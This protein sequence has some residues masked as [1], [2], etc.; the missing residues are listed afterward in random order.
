MAVFKEKTPCMA[1][2]H[3]IMDLILYEMKADIWLL[4]SS[5]TARF[6]FAPL[7]GPADHS[8]LITGCSSHHSYLIS[9]KA[10]LSVSL[11]S[12]DIKY[13]RENPY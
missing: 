1:S 6:R 12:F 13:V 7:R 10:P 4:H 8:Q 2:L 5:F 11:P 3:Y 9:K